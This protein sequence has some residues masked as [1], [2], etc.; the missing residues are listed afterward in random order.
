MAARREL[1]MSGRI[2]VR[3]G[4]KE[5]TLQN[6][7]KQMLRPRTNGKPP[8]PV[9]AR[10]QL[11][12]EVTWKIA[13]PQTQAR[14]LAYSICRSGDSLD[15]TGDRVGR[16]DRIR[17]RQDP[18][19]SGRLKAKIHSLRDSPFS[20]LQS[21]V[22]FLFPAPGLFLPPSTCSLQASG[23]SSSRSAH[24]IL[25]CQQIPINAQ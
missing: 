14:F 17:L 18:R 20:N 7:S 3:E 13:F 10:V 6:A 2:G 22:S 15:H 16:I 5:Q 23:L 21:P 12:D 24:T 9:N 1:G 25:D 8:T 19:T 11:S 4:I